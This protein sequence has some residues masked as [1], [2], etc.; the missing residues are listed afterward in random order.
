MNHTTKPIVIKFGGTS[1]SSQKTLSTIVEIA[2]RYRSENPVLVVSAVSGVTDSLLTCAKMPSSEI[3]AHINTILEKHEK[4]AEAVLLSQE[5]RAEVITYV[6]EQLAI[7]K[8]IVETQSFSPKQMDKLASFGEIMS[9]FLITKVLQQAS[10]E[11]QQVISSQLIITD[12]NFMNA[13]FFPAETEKQVKKIL[14][15]LLKKN[16]IPVVTG[17][18]GA[19]KK[20]EVTTLGRSGSDYSAS[21]VAYSLNAR[22]LQIWTDVDGVYSADPRVVK[23]A[24][25]IPTMSYS[26]AA[27]MALFGAKVLHPR[28]I[29]PAV[30]KEIPV[31]V[32]NTFHPT[33]SGTLIKSEPAEAGLKGISF[34]RKTTL[35]NI[36]STSMLLVPGFLARVFA[37]FAKNA[38]SID[39]V[40]VSEVSVSLTLDNTTHLHKATKELEKFCNVTVSEEFGMISL[41]GEKLVSMQHLL[42]EVAQLFYAHDIEIRMVSMG[43]SDIN[44]SLII[45][46]E[47]IEKAAQLVHDKVLLLQRVP[48]YS[49]EIV[50]HLHLQQ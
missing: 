22:E 46:S 19:T 36:Y 15:P 32:L 7:V 38:I 8:K 1:V 9:S 4:L 45:N 37:I 17:F 20:G 16:I 34:K 29:H 24:R 42:K 12:D 11:A 5:K 13:E 30:K 49:K 48:P 44:I 33:A 18:I 21:I 28:T 40:A 39:L 31:R 2:S 10:L 3:D 43:A 41:I 14:A 25:L 35:V 27:E 50:T 6:K 47:E 26:E 23:N